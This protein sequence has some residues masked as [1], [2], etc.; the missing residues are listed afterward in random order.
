VPLSSTGTADF[1]DHCHRCALK[2]QCT[3]ARDG[4]KV[5]LGPEQMRARAHRAAADPAFTADYRQHRPMVERT[6]A[7]FTRPGRRTPYRGLTKTDAWVKTRAAAINLKRLHTMGLTRQDGQ[8]HL[9][10]TA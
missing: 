1:T 8:W 4:R 5:R 3:K 7:W 6:I 2:D 9:A 10:A